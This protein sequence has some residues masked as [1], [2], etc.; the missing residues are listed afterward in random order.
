MKLFL[1]LALGLTSLC[2][3]LLALA[4]SRAA[5]MED[6]KRH[7]LQTMNLDPLKEILRLHALYLDGDPNG[8]RADLRQVDLQGANLQ[9]VNLQG[10]L[11]PHFQI[12]MGDLIVFKKLSAGVICELLI[13]AA[14]RRTA[15]LVGRKCR[16]E[17]AIVKSGSGISKRDPGFRYE[18]G[19]TVR[20]DAYDDDIRI[21][22]APGIHFFCT[23][24]EAE[25]Y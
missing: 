17:Y 6:A 3:C 16:A 4:L 2:T 20:P 14:A 10:A 1:M 12:P 18:E 22:C 13:P 19:A 8:K 25:E 15:T 11:L 5:S 7:S 23:R 21:E 24:A 9:G